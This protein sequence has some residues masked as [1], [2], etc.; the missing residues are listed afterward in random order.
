[1][2]SWYNAGALGQGAKEGPN[3]LPMVWRSI[4]TKRLTVRGFIISDHVD[5]FPDFAREVA[6]H[7]QAGRLKYRETIAQGLESAPQA[8]IELLRGKNF[9]KQLVAI[10][11]D[12]TRN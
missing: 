8:F 4:L 3:L 11:P 5:R 9:G 6:G 7:L 2:I 1:M 10:S 12:P